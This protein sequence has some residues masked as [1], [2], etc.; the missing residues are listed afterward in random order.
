MWDGLILLKYSSLGR[1]IIFKGKHVNK[2]ITN[3]LKF[4][5]N[6]S[7]DITIKFHHS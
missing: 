3:N 1:S 4:S 2:H 7:L 6:S 5:E